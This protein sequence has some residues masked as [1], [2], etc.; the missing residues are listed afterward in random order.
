MVIIAVNLKIHPHMEFNNIDNLKEAGFSGFKPVK[1]LVNNT[2]EIP[3]IKG[4]YLILTDK[5]T[6][7]AYLKVGTGGHF[8]GKDPNV[9]IDELK[10]NW[11]ENTI[12]VYVGKAGGND[13]KATLRL[14]LQQYFRFGSG[15]K[16]GHWGG[17][18]IWQLAS[19]PD[20]VVCWKPLPE[21]D[22]R[23]EEHRLIADF[24]SQYGKRPF[25]NLTN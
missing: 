3:A 11:V 16:V 1:H 4:I 14:R 24:V 13:S 23:T 6:T 17:R 22:P 21:D 12:V 25:A 2:S 18:L 9:Q 20:L 8:K 7:P 15:K 10:K 19:S 5:N